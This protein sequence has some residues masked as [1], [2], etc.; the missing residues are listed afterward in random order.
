MARFQAGEIGVLVATTVIEVGVDVPAASLMIV[1][2]AENFGLAQL[3]QLR[4]RVGRGAAK[5]V[6]LLLR[7]QNLSETARER[8]A[9][10][11]DTNDGFVIAEKDL[12]LRGGGELLGLKQ[13]G[14]ADYR[15]ATPE[16]LVRLLPV[17]HDDARLFVER[18]GGIEGARGEAVRLCLYLFERD[19]AVPLLRSG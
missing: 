17:A 16:Q 3:H 8:L 6:C 7:S 14:D 15:V 19:A 18:D 12:E 11:R 9:L 10:M 5:S 13:S 4:G 2:H 1:E